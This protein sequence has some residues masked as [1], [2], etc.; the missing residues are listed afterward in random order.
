MGVREFIAEGAVMITDT[1]RAATQ[2]R[3]GRRKA[4][5]LIERHSVDAVLP[6]A[7]PQTSVDT[8][9]IVAV[10]A[11]TGGTEALREII[12]TLPPNAPGMVVVQHM[13]EGFTAAFAKRLNSLSRVEVKEAVNGDVIAP[14]R[15]LIAPGSHHLLVRRSGTGYFAQLSAGALVS[16]HRPSV[17]VLFRSVAQ[18]AGANAIGVILTG[19]GDDGAQ[20]LAEM[21]AAGA[22]TIAQDEATSVIFGMPKE[23]IARGAI[24]SVLGLHK[25]AGAI[26]RMG[27]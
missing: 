20:G 3:V 23:A 16:R 26:M 21:R 6:A 24:D 15:V 11:S 14:G 25:I 2:A 7:A 12:E 27:G 10:G 5:P 9:R 13:P 22:T 4:M 1:L 19:M 8:P 17:D 18:S